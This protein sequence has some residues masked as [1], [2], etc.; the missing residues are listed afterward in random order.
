MKICNAKVYNEKRREFSEGSVE[1]DNGIITAI[2]NDKDGDIDAKG[3]YLIPG[4]I[5]VHSHGRGGHD[6]MSADT[7]DIEKCLD[8]Y[9]SHG[10]TTVFPCVMTGRY[11]DIKKAIRKIKAAKSDINIDGIHIEGP[12]VSPKRPGCHDISLLRKLDCGEAN[13]LIS[14]IKPLK[15]HITVA[16]ELD[17]GDEFIKECI[18][19]GAT[20][21]I[22]HSDAVYAGAMHALDL[23]CV[24]FTHTFNAMRELKHREPGTVGAAL[25]GAGYA[26]FICDLFH[27]CAP[28]LDISY[29]AVGCEKFVIVSD[30]I[31]A[32]D[33]PDGIYYLSG[34]QVNVKDGKAMNNDGAIAGS[35]T[36]IFDE[37]CNLYRVL[38]RPLEE[39]VMTAT[40]N[41]AKQ[42][43]IFDKTGS[44]DTGK[45]ADMLLIEADGYELKLKTVISKGKI[46]RNND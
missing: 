43:G 31:A 18:K 33:M 44:I 10:V 41:P 19:D 9:L 34:M 2:S 16:P 20:V 29:R 11:E 45:R 23:G 5:D 38:K 37:L 15:T 3:A 7:E 35:T 40:S 6:F 4:L 25:S 1:F 27:V 39:L 30:S 8:L 46:I 32:A 12:Y 13:E 22:G 36:N 26:E 21:G 14:L 24:S 42:V 28:V 17:N